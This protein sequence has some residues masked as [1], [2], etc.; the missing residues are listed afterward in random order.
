MLEAAEGARPYTLSSYL[1]GT[2]PQPPFD[3]ELY[4]AFGVLIAAFHDA[5]D[6]F[7][8]R[9]PR[10]QPAAEGNLLRELAGAVRNH[11]AQYSGALAHG[12]CHGDVSLDN[13]FVTADG[14]ALYDFDL[15]GDNYRTSESMV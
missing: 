6:D 1:T 4:Y 9:A 2:K 13:L 3:D 7:P 11:L 14:L 10:P 12:T 15:S 8:P 5:T